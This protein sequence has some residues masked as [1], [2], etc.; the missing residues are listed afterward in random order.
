MIC[1]LV[2][3]Q[4]LLLLM[5]LVMRCSRVLPKVGVEPHVGIR[6]VPNPRHHWL[7]LL[8]LRLVRRVGR[9]AV[10]GRFLDRPLHWIVGEHDSAA[11]T[12]FLR[13]LEVDAVVKV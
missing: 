13:L 6:R 12:G 9:R 5:W 4:G 11:E 8:L 3:G 7:V 10:D 2:M 1:A